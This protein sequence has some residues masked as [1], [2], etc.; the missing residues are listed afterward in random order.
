[1]LNLTRCWHGTGIMV[2]VHQ[3]APVPAQCHCHSRRTNTHTSRQSKTVLQ[4]LLH[5]LPSLSRFL[6]W[7]HLS[8][9][10]TDPRLNLSSVSPNTPNSC[11]CILNAETLSV[12]TYFCQIYVHVL[13]NVSKVEHTQKKKKRV[14][15]VHHLN[16]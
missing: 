6:N 5:F 10:H 15:T 1:M 7:H 11:S 4:L 13:V 12:Y 16:L 14:C 8:L 9:L 2:S 3:T